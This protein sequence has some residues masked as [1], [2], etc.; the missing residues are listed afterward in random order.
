MIF[1]CYMYSIIEFLQTY[2]VPRKCNFWLKIKP[3]EVYKAVYS[4]LEINAT[5][6]ITTAHIIHLESVSRAYI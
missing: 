4:S 1:Q 5:K 3:R 2:T 6:N